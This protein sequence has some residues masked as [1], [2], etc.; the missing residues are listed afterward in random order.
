MGRS[1]GA[2]RKVY[3]PKISADSTRFRSYD[4][5]RWCRFYYCDYR[6][7]PPGWG[8]GVGLT[9]PPCKNLLSRTSHRICEA[10]RGLQEL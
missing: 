9:T 3:L 10:V 4:G 5:L 1:L 6:L 7:G 2:K 8:L